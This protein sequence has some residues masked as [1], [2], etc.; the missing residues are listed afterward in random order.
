MKFLVSGQKNV[1]FNVYFWFFLCFFLKK[2]HD[3]NECTWR[4][5]V[6]IYAITHIPDLPTMMHHVG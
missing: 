1:Y 4:V 5:R 2:V 6:S 3:M